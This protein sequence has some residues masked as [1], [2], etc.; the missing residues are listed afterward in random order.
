LQ[1]ERE[2]SFIVISANERESE[3]NDFGLIVGII[4]EDTDQTTVAVIWCCGVKI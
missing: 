4:K 3:E 2:R 1:F